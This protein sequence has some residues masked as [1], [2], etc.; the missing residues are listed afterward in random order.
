MDKPTLYDLCLKITSGFE[1][2]SFGTVAGNFD[3]MGISA[4]LLQW[5]LGQGTLQSFILS[6]CDLMSFNFPIPLR[7]LQQMSP[8]DSVVWAKDH[9]LDANGKLLPEW[10]AA[11]IEFLTTPSVVNVQKRAIDK[12][13]QR[14][15]EIAGKLGFSHEHVRAMCWA[16]DV[17][18]QDGSCDIDRP[19]VNR[20][21]ANIVMSKYSG[22]NYAL[23]VKE[24]L[25][26][27]QIVLVIAS[28][29]RALQ[30]RAA[31]REDVFSRK[32]TIATGIGIVHKTLFNYKKLL[33]SN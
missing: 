18:V 4:G 22:D 19:D 28:H 6:Q 11:W 15:K 32:C 27:D 30:S 3:G 23:W 16:F 29:L 26:D 33:K 12:Y 5:N 1:G 9:M 31:Y 20:E 14:A 17:A 24:E 10:K 8:A 7:P 13:F 2:T 25:D 21:Q